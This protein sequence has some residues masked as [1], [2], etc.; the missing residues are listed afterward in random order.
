MIRRTDPYIVLR[1]WP[2]CTQL[3]CVTLLACVY[4]IILEVIFVLC[5]CVCVCVCVYAE[6]GECG[7]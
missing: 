1:Y 2:V 5:V 3:Y 4:T 6:G 7:M